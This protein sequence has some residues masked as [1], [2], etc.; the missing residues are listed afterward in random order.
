[1]FNFQS[2]DK[3]LS[4]WDPN[5]EICFLEKCVFKSVKLTDF[6]ENLE[7]FDFFISQK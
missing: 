4:F 7:N 6:D 5:F 3:I 2:V 1:M